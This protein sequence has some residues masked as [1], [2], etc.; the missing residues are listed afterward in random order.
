MASIEQVSGF[1]HFDNSVSVE[2]QHKMLAF[3][4]FAKDNF[5][6]EFR[7]SYASVTVGNVEGKAYDDFIP[8]NCEGGFK[9]T[10][11]YRN[12]VDPC[13][14]FTK[15]QTAWKDKQAAQSLFDFCKEYKVNTDTALSEEYEDKLV[16]WEEDFHEPALLELRCIITKGKVLVDLSLDYKG[17][18]TFDWNLLFEKEF[19]VSE[20][21]ELE[22]KEFPKFDYLRIKPEDVYFNEE[23]EALLYENTFEKQDK[24][25]HFTDCN[26]EFGGLTLR[27]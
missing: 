22:F 8:I 24:S 7:D 16:E 14:H 6:S 11:Q 5:I 25:G 13:S 21:M 15:E 27:P 18:A 2:L 26:H 20:F 12:D 3:V 9:V 1:E 23:V 19:T 10:E 17:G 4:N